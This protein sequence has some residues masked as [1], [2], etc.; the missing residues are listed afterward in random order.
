MTTEHE[1][2]QAFQRD[3]AALIP[4]MRAFAR[5]LCMNS[6]HGDDLAQDGLLKAWKSR[7]SYTPGTNLKAW[8]FMI[9]RNQFLSE[10]RRSWRQCSLDQGVA[11]QT[12]VAVSDPS[13]ALELN[14]LRCAMACLPVEQREALVL[15]GAAGMSY[16]DVSEICGV[17]VGTVKSRV[18]RARVRLQEILESGDFE[19]DDI[20]G[21]DAMAAIFA[22]V[23][24]LRMRVAA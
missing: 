4:S 12:L 24:Y 2:D 17:A 16:E 14:D 8:T 22:Q 3:L 1:Q 11:E 7:A 10:K 13:A 23:D 19:S 15:I 21:G 18:S 20:R 6:V 9:I 5:S